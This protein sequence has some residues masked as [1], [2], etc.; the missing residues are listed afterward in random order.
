MWK[1]SKLT[2]LCC[3][4]IIVS[5]LV[6]GIVVESSPAAMLFRP[7]FLRTEIGAPP[8]GLNP[9]SNGVASAEPIPEVAPVVSQENQPLPVATTYQ[10]RPPGQEVALP[11]SLGG[12][13]RNFVSTWLALT[14]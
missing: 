6:A 11:L 4:Y 8:P 2:R 3:K 7:H 1:M 10:S 9:D 12:Y 13:I 5:L 14:S